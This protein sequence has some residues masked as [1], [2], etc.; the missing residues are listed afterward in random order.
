VNQAHL[1]TCVLQSH[2]SDKAL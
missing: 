2:S 1:L